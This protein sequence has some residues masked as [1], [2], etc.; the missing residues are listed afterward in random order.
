MQNYRYIR[1]IDRSPI[2]MGVVSAEVARAIVATAT[3]M[4]GHEDWDFIDGSL[5][6]KDADTRLEVIRLEPIR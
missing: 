4:G 2:D 5:L 3:F 6:V 1:F